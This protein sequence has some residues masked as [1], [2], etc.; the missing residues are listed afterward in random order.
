MVIQPAQRFRA[1]E[2]SCDI[3]V[4]RARYGV[5]VCDGRVSWVRAECKIAREAVR[6]C[7][8]ICRSSQ[9]AP[10]ELH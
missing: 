5:P 3:D 1:C 9:V 4:V 6:Y 10:G 2:A 7:G 8:S